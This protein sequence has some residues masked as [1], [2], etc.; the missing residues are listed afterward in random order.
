MI[1][2]RLRCEYLTNPLGIDVVRPRFSWALES[3]ERGVVQIGF[4]V[5]VASSEG[6]LSE[7]VGDKWDSGETLSGETTG[8]EYDGAP[9]TSGER[10]WWKVRVW[11]RNGAITEPEQAAWFEMGLLNP[12]DWAAEWIGAA[13]EISAPLLRREFALRGPISR[14]RA[15]VSGLGYYEMCINGRRVGDN[16]LD[17]AS[18]SYNDAGQ[19]IDKPGRV[20]YVTHDVTDQL[21]PGVNAL[22]VML[23]NGWYGD[24]Y[25]GTVPRAGY[26]DRPKLLLQLNVEYADGTSEAIVSDDT[27]KASPGPITSNDIYHGE[28]YDARLEQDG[29]TSPGFD[30]AQWD[31]AIV[32]DAPGGVLSAQ[33][34]PPTKVVGSIRPVSV[35]NPADGVYI[36]DMGQHFSGWA[37]LRVAGERGTRITMRFAGALHEDGTLDVSNNLEARATDVYT[38]RGGGEEL[39][40]PRFTFHGF[41][42]VEI[43]GY[44]GAPTVDDVEGRLVRTALEQSG[45]FE[46]SND[47]LNRIHDNALRTFA[48]TFQGIPQDAAD[49][50][51]R[52]GWLGDP[53]FIAEDMMI[54]FDSASF[55]SKWLVDIRDTQRA[56]GCLPVVSPLHFPPQYAWEEWPAWQS[57]YPLFVRVVYERYGDKRVLAEHYDAMKRLVAFLG[58][59]ADGHILRY[60]LGD[61]M[62]PQYGSDPP[63]SS[64]TPRNT[65]PALTSTAYYYRDTVI[66]ADAARVLGEA[67]EA[68]RHGALAEEIRKAFNAEFLDEETGQYATGSQTSNALPLW[69]G[70]VPEEKRTVVARNLVEH[71]R[72][73]TDG[74]LATGIIG[75]GRAGAGVAR[76]RLRR[77]HVRHPHEDDVPEPRVLDPPRRDDAVGVLRG[78]KPEPEHEDVRRRLQVLLREPCGHQTKRARLPPHRRPSAAGRRSHLRQGLD[79]HDTRPGRGGLEAQR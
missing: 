4:Q 24:D 37:R 10:C 20:L 49:R 31:E 59:K 56:D 8:I 64:F 71:I 73:K 12:D 57:S 53:G 44:P 52:V 50:S 35:S 30:E 62:E 34:L 33:M 1:P 60:G 27:W 40:E 39:W 55:W 15:Y 46:C 6:N 61:H 77:R 54:N 67:D 41:R 69:L 65:P 23:G 51:E 66:V 42:Y 70:M 26:G 48:G 28:E 13:E 25:P 79:G 7:G 45:G 17:P 5:L 72:N 16:V 21:A 78:E 43:S 19:P 68:E 18:T 14:A 38:L 3:D 63:E 2:T 75:N 47:L 36:V 76:L 9:L 22:G 58:G 32:V 74:H 11:D 29:W